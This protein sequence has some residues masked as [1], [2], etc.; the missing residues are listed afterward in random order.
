MRGWGWGGGGGQV[1]ECG[2]IWSKGTGQGWRGE[3]WLRRC[4]LCLGEGQQAG[5]V[6]IQDATG[7]LLWTEK[8]EVVW[9]VPFQPDRSSWGEGA[10]W[11]GRNAQV[12]LPPP[13]LGPV[14]PSKLVTPPSIFAFLSAAVITEVQCISLPLCW[15]PSP[16]HTPFTRVCTSVAAPPGQIC[17]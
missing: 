13:G 15:V 1:P 8:K 6:G 5:V 7:E 11:T 4:L 12:F 17:V 9:K 3:H 2:N 14:T 10:E 16:P